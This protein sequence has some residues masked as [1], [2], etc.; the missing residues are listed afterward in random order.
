VLLVEADAEQPSCRG[1][2]GTAPAG[3][4]AEGDSVSD[5]HG[6][7]AV[8]VPGR[9]RLV[10]LADLDAYVAR[11][12]QQGVALGRLRD[13]TSIMHATLRVILNA[14]VDDGLIVANPADK[15]G[16]ALKLVA[17]ARV[18]QEHVKAF[19]RAQRDTFLTTAAKIEPWWAPMWDVQALSGLRP[20]EVYALQEADLDLDAAT[21]RIVRTLADDGKSVDTPKGNRG[22]TIDLS[23]RA[24]QVLR[25]HIATR[26]AMK[27]KHSWCEMPEPFFCSQAGTY[28]DP[29]EHPRRLRPGGEEGEA[30]P[31]PP[32]RPP[33]HL[34]E[35]APSRRDGRILREQDARAREYPGNRRHVRP[36]P[37]GEPQGRARR[38]RCLGEDH[39]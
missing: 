22:R 38:A 9:L 10:R 25:T 6:P 15:L 28:P 39:S 4:R 12:R 34:C 3:H 29:P 35:S 14:A 18:R 32:P 13:V 2:G 26:K 1:D 36:L 17:K 24:V 11:C 33:A 19:D 23:A 5:A 27:L 30:S 37:P 31:R 7:R 21:A 16:R 8:R 20:G